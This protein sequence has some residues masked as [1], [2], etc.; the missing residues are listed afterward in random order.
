MQKKHISTSSSDINIKDYPFHRYIPIE[1]IS[2]KQKKLMKNKLELNKVGIIKVVEEP[3]QEPVKEVNYNELPIYNIISTEKTNHYTLD[4][5]NIIE[6][7]TEINQETEKNKYILDQQQQIIITNQYVIQEQNNKINNNNV[8]IQNNDALIQQQMQI[9]N[10][11]NYYTEQQNIEISNNQN[12]I[13]EQEEQLNNIQNK[14]FESESELEGYKQ[15]IMFNGSMLQLFN[16]FTH[17]Y[18]NN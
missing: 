14:I 1:D 8:I 16:I 13:I 18:Y 17:N 4:N 12:R 6:R 3:V 15:Q 9:Y 11:N 5:K 2:K 10:N 7:L